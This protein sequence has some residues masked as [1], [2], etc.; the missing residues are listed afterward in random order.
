MGIKETLERFTGIEINIGPSKFRKTEPEKKTKFTPTEIRRAAGE[1]RQ[2]L[3]L[4]CQYFLRK[5]QLSPDDF[6][7]TVSS[8]IELVGGEKEP[9]EDMET[10]NIIQDSKNKKA[11]RCFRIHMGSRNYGYIEISQGWIVPS[12]DEDPYKTWLNTSDELLITETFT[13][14]HPG[15]TNRP[16]F[17]YEIQ[18]PVNYEGP[19]FYSHVLGENVDLIKSEKVLPKKTVSNDRVK[20]VLKSILDI[21]KEQDE[22]SRN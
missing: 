3:V 20:A 7:Q 4:D 16:E 18:I 15:S 1:Q 21:I 19:K 22:Q 13:H 6:N 5:E 17:E 11:I 9:T 2:Q 8:L 10:S 12:Y 14:G